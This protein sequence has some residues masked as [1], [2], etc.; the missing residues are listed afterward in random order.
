[1]IGVILITRGNFGEKMLE[2]AAAI[3]GP[4]EK[5][6]SYSFS[7]GTEPDQIKEEIIKKIEESNCPEGILILTDM[8]GG[9]P[10]NIA[11]SVVKAL[12]IEGLGQKCEIVSGFN[13]YML[14]SVLN[15]RY[16]LSL[17][18]LVTKAITDGKKNIVAVKEFFLQK[19]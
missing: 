5:V 11:L 2:A 14:I 10:C 18:E 16:S 1:M 6:C 12:E 13:L 17:E 3:L 15:Q 8:C 4:Q 7:V 19:E 9:T